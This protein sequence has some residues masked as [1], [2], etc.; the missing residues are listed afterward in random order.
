[1]GLSLGLYLC[2]AYLL[3]WLIVRGKI[4]A[5]SYNLITTIVE[6]SFRQYALQENVLIVL[7]YGDNFVTVAYLLGV[8][9]GAPWS[10]QTMTN[11]ARG[12]HVLKFVSVIWQPISL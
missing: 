5:K 12:L 11:F 3:A 9:R 4:R 6:L 1:M 8:Q 10:N 2:L 7:S